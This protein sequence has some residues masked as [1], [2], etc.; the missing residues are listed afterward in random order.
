MAAFPRYNI[1]MKEE[2]N[3]YPQNIIFLDFD[4][5]M[6]SR[7]EGGYLYHDPKEYG[8]DREIVKRLRKLCVECNARI[9]ISSNWRKFDIGQTFTFNGKTVENPLPKLRKEL[10][11]YIFDTLPPEKYIRKSEC[12]LLWFDDNPGF[13][14]NYIILDDDVSEGFYDYPQLKSHFICCDAEFGLTDEIC[15]A[16]KKILVKSN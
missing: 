5:V 6:T 16:I 9:V 8:F 2:K 1:V 13:K 3:I 15:S 11:D 14:G 7:R 12:T 4:G 10:G